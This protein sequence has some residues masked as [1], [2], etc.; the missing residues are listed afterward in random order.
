VRPSSGLPPRHSGLH[1]AL[2]E[3]GCQ[4]IRM[5]LFLLTPDM[6][7]QPLNIRWVWLQVRLNGEAEP[8]S[9]GGAN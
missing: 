3:A 1:F 5:A 2:K 6:L 8:D 4:H 9:E 7:A